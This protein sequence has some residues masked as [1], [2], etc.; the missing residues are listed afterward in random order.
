MELETLSLHRPEPPMPDVDPEPV[1]PDDDD[2]LPPDMPEPYRHPKGDPPQ[3]VPPVRMPPASHG[4]ERGN[5]GA[6]LPGRR[7]AGSS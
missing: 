7:D 4:G 1:P 6:A 5:Y 3:R 2:D